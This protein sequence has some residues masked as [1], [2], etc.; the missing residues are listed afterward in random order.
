MIYFGL[1]TTALLGICVLLNISQ[2]LKLVETLGL[3][4]PIGIGLQ[5]F[6]MVA[7]DLLG[8]RLTAT[9]MLAASWVTIAGAVGLLCLRRNLLKDWWKYAGKPTYPKLSWLWM[10]A[11]LA[12]GVVLTM[13]FAKT[14]FTPPFDT[15]SLRGFDLM[16]KIVA[17]EGTIKNY[18]V[19]TDPNYYQITHS[20]GS[21]I[22]YTPLVQLSSAYVY[23]LGAATSKIFPGLMFISFVLA[24]YGVTSRFVTHTLAALATFFTAAT[25]EMLAFSSMSGTN[26]IHAI[27][28]SLGTLFFITWYYKKIPSLLWVAAV[29]LMLNNWVR[30]EGVAFIG[31]ACCVMLWHSIPRLAGQ[32]RVTYK[33]LFLFAGL[34]LLP[35]VF[36]QVFLRLNHWNVEMTLVLYLYWDRVVVIAEGLWWLFTSFTLYGLTFVCFLV[37]LLSNVWAIILKRDHAVTLLFIL[38]VWVFYTI[39][40]YL[41]D[42]TWD[43]GGMVAIMHSSYKRFLFSFVPLLWFYVAASYNV[44]WL[45]DQLNS[46]LYPVKKPKVKK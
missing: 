46:F 24:F 30:N 16:G 6:E 26:V 7:L 13:S 41:V 25:P 9:T 23:M 28:A 18:S 1:S 43:A 20:P 5:T 38:L 19:F 34:C 40:V 37:A 2:R 14:M 27:Y 3:A 11:L 21:Y 12:V 29:L 39:L 33:R 8:V 15:D 35:F 17:Q 4:F 36:W 32:T 42:P 22:S 10:L 31:A 45:F 44:R